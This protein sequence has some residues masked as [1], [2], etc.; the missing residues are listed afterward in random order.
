MIKNYSP[1]LFFFNLIVLLFFLNNFN[2]YSQVAISYPSA[3]QDVTVNYFGAALTVR[4]DISQNLIT[5][6]NV[7]INLPSGISYV[8][9][10]LFKINS[11]SGVTITY[12][13]GTP[14]SPQFTVG[15]NNL[16]IG[17]F[18]VFSISRIANCTARTNSVNGTIFKDAISL[19]TSAGTIQ[20]TSTLIN[21]YI[22]NYP[23]FSL[24][25]PTSLS[26]AILGQ[27][28][29]RTFSITN[30]GTGCT[31]N[32][33]FSVDYPAGDILQ[34]F[35]KCNGIP[36]FPI[37]TVG[38][39]N[40][41]TI[42]GAIL[43]ASQEFCSGDILNF[44]ESFKVIKCD[45]L[46]NYSTGWGID[47]NPA[48]R[49]QTDVG[50]GTVTMATGSPLLTA[51]NNTLIG[52]TNKCNPFTIRTT[53]TNNGTGNVGA[54]TMYNIV[55]KKCDVYDYYGYP[56][57]LMVFGVANIN[58]VSIPNQLLPAN[59]LAISGPG[60]F[61]EV[62]TSNFFTSDPDGPGVGLDDIDK[63]GF[64]DD[65]PSG[66]TVT[67]NIAASYNCSL[68]PCNT[69]RLMY[70][71]SSMTKYNTMCDNTQLIS[72]LIQPSGNVITDFV[73]SHV[74][75]GS[76]PANITPLV[77]FRIRVNESS[78]FNVDTFR[79]ANSRFV[80]EIT[81][82]AG[83]TVSGTGNPTK[84]YGGGAPITTTITQVGNVIRFS[85]I[86]SA[87]I[88]I[89]NIDLIYNC[90][91]GGNV[92]S[93]TLPYKFIEINDIVA[94]C[95]CNS[96]I[97]C[98]VLN[99]NTFCPTTCSGAV[100]QLPIVERAASSY[101]WTNNTLT[102]RQSKAN[103][104]AFDLSKALYL[105]TIEI[106]SNGSQT[107]NSNNLGLHFELP[108]TASGVNKLTPINIDVQLIRFGIAIRTATLTS[109]VMTGS[110]ATTQKIDWDLTPILISG[111]FQNGD[112]FRT[113]SRYQ[114]TS[115]ELEFHDT[116]SGGLFY[117]FNTTGGGVKQNCN[118]FV[119][120]MYLVGTYYINGNNPQNVNGCNQTAL[121]GGT[122]YLA[123]RFDSS[124]IVFQ[125]EY[126]PGFLVTSIKATM[127]LDYNFV[128]AQYIDVVSGLSVPIVPS[129]IVGQVYTF[130]N[131]G[132]WPAFPITV[133]NNYGAYVPFTIQATCATS[134]TTYRQNSFEINYKDYYYA[135]G[136]PSVNTY[137]TSTNRDQGITYANPPDIK[138][139]NLSG[140][141]QVTRP[142]ESF[143]FRLSSVGTSAA[144]YSW[145]AI[146][147]IPGITITQVV[148]VATNSVIS[149]I[150]YPNGNL[151][152]L[153]IAP[154]P[155]SSFLDYRIF[156]TISACNVSSFQVLG[157]WNCNN[158]PTDPD[159][160][161]C[162]KDSLTFNFTQ[163][164]AEVQVDETTVPTTVVV[165]C[166]PKDYSFQVINSQSGNVTQNKFILKMPT[167]LIPVGGSFEVEYPRGSGD[168]EPLPA[169]TIL[170]NEYT[171]NLFSHSA[172]PVQ[173]IPGTLNSVTL[174][175]RFISIRFKTTTDCNYVP[176]NKFLYSTSAL[177][178]C[179][180]FATGSNIDNLSTN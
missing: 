47:S 21:S 121:G 139:T 84:T 61:Y 88:Y 46:T 4:L 113:T 152:Y 167:G 15:P 54:A 102:T 144:P 68:L 77:P 165:L 131:P 51:T 22:I 153:N 108:K 94:N 154:L 174:D 20:D 27:T 38:T 100:T 180:S 13:G 19:A 80:Y 50:T 79:T 55:L 178:S 156:F 64:F 73:Y 119:A 35:L 39:I 69:D 11:T 135:Y 118:A 126:R 63:D 137:N 26:N 172:Y 12:I 96:D 34:I 83:V 32:V 81:L 10:S 37:S 150:A 142:T 42:T 41:Y 72:N 58:G 53:F 25:Q 74:L 163:V 111:V 17:N 120:E 89:G 101:G 52:F 30:G 129:S 85:E 173:G 116:Q 151:Y 143:L 114:V 169:P 128:S 82:P 132:T 122:N 5:G 179:G 43:N 138:L 14:S 162:S 87:G 92:N 134:T 33:Y 98:G 65:L 177:K 29:T 7:T 106:K 66:A 23:A 44:E 125:N 171:Y 40:Y 130:N 112:T 158:F 36:I 95:L 107:A 93:L 170:S 8:P 166:A 133:T 31:E 62:N 157:G 123:R 28:Y 56:S 16:N 86:A 6:C 99:T 155:T 168:W 45:G 70:I 110:T 148:D 175:D 164:T 48:N 49:C 90:A 115:N 24:S 105:D 71:L 76:A 147:N 136:D 18:I 2:T 149:P 91:V 75:T 97:A 9:N 104:S 146:P 109:F 124:G 67:L 145:I 117:F 141:I 127:P 159:L 1:K 176:G 57:T 161:T 140:T 60:K 3:A 103:I 59:N 160:F 78:Y